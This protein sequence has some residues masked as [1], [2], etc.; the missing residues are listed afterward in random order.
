MSAPR[1]KR[2]IFTGLVI[3]VVVAFPTFSHAQQP[4]EIRWVHLIGGEFN[5]DSRMLIDDGNNGIVAVG[6]TG[7]AMEAESSLFCVHVDSAGALVWYR[8]F[9]Y[10]QVTKAKDIIRLDSGGYLI[11]GYRL[12]ND[13]TGMDALLLRLD[14]NGNLIWDRL[15]EGS[16]DDVAWRSCQVHQGFVVIGITESN[17]TQQKNSFFAKL[18]IQGE[19]QW[20]RQHGSEYADRTTTMTRTADGGFALAGMTRNT[21]NQLDNGWLVR[22]DSNGNVLWE[23]QYGGERTDEFHWVEALTDGGFILCGRTMSNHDREDFDHWVVRTD[24]DGNELASFSGG[25]NEAN[26]WAQMVQPL[27]T[28]FIVT[29]RGHDAQNG[30]QVSLGYFT[31]NLSEV[32]LVDRGYP[33]IDMAYAVRVMDDGGLAISGKATQPDAEFTDLLIARTEPHIYSPEN[34]QRDG[35]RGAFRVILSRVD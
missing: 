7:Q 20:V 23:R 5:D 3:A 32:Y 13:G 34:L 29:G 12:D 9:D 8:V 19:V 2:L 15:I 10:G 28:G 35:Q 6:F 18:N 24:A 22:T 4:P 17:P 33:S 25:V 31:S 30:K 27:G 26:D 11:T 16:E 14:A 21:S 1:R